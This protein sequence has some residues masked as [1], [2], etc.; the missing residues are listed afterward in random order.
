[1]MFVT[2]Q[3]GLLVARFFLGLTEAGF[4]PGMVF[5]FTFWFKVMTVATST[6]AV[7]ESSRPSLCP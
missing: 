2:N 6:I 3:A 5:Y 4:F 1:M 7:I